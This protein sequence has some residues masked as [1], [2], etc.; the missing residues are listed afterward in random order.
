VVKQRAAESSPAILISDALSRNVPKLS[1]G[2]EL[3][4]ANCLTQLNGGS[5]WK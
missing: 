3:L 5:L 4:F 2:V 1:V